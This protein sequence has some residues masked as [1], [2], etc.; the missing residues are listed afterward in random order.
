MI[1][2]LDMSIGTKYITTGRKK[3]KKLTVKSAEHPEFYL[4]SKTLSRGVTLY[5]SSFQPFYQSPTKLS[6]DVRARN[7]RNGFFLN[8]ND[9]L[10]DLFV[11]MAD[12]STENGILSWTWQHLHSAPVTTKNV[13][14]LII[15]WL[16][17]IMY[18]YYLKKFP[19]SIVCVFVLVHQ[20]LC[21]LIVYYWFMC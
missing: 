1:C 16:D 3:T 17:N 13:V 5:I 4:K 8:G 18:V 9:A 21:G 12:G 14:Q 11:Y 15:L 19:I 6:F 7:L 2:V 10:L 20:M